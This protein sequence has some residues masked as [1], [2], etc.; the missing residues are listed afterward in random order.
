LHSPRATTAVPEELVNA[1]DLIH[2][3]RR[4][5]KLQNRSLG[6]STKTFP[7][8]ARRH[9]NPVGLVATP[10]IR[11][12]TR[13]ELGLASQCANAGSDPHPRKSSLAARRSCMFTQH[14]G[15]DGCIFRIEVITNIV[16]DNHPCAFEA[17]RNPALPSVGPRD[18]VLGDVPGKSDRADRARLLAPIGSNRTWSGLLSLRERNP[19]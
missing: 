1:G 5:T 13:I 9:T 6:L 18:V 3:E 4:G 2:F 7:A 10:S 15:R 14:D 11:T 19:F 12:F 16:A 17:C 8:S